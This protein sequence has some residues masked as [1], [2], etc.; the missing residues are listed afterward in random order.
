MYLVS[1]T[2]APV[3][4]SRALAPRTCFPLYSEIGTNAAERVSQKCLVI[5]PNSVPCVKGRTM[6]YQKAA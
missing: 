4:G 5:Y 6:V 1:Q 2:P 3:Q